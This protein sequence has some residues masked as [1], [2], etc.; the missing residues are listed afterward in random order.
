MTAEGGMD[1]KL[2]FAFES[3]NDAG[4]CPCTPRGNDSLDLDL[5]VIKDCLGKSESCEGSA[6]N[7]PQGNDSLDLDLAGEHSSPLRGVETVFYCSSLLQCVQNDSIK[8]ISNS[9][10]QSGDFRSLPCPLGYLFGVGFTF[11]TTASVRIP[12]SSGSS[13]VSTPVNLPPKIL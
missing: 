3:P 5:D 6:L 11:S 2:R 9:T 7:L 12:Y 13:Y 10:H 8:K 4:L 1:A